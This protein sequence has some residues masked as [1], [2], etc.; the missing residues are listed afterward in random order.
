MK[1]I[2]VRITPKH[3]FNFKLDQNNHDIYLYMLYTG[4]AKNHFPLKKGAQTCKL[5]G[6]QHLKGIMFKT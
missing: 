3:S 5:S 2:F 4:L 6:D 1:Y